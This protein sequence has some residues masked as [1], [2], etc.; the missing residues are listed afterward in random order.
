MRLLIVP[1]LHPTKPETGDCESQAITEV[2]MGE[3]SEDFARDGAFV[4]R[5]LL[6]TLQVKN[7]QAGIDANLAHPRTQVTI[8]K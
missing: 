5:N 6:S 2:K 4:L 3:L 8:E 7:L 1:R